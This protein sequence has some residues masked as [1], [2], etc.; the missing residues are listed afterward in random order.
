MTD[1]DG[2]GPDGIAGLPVDEAVDAVLARGVDEDRETVRA[3]LSEVAADGVVTWE[4]AEAALAH[5]SK[6]VSTPET[7][8]ELAAMEL[9]E[10]REAAEPVAEVDAV[11]S[12]LDAFAARLETVEERNV[13]LGTDLQA[14]VDRD[15]DLYAVARGVARLTTAA[16]RVQGTADELSTD[17]QEFQRWLANPAVRYDGLAED[18]AQGEQSIE[19]LTAVVD[20]IEDAVLT[21]GAADPDGEA[22]RSWLDGTLQHRVLELLAADLRAELA[23]IRELSGEAP[24]RAA[25]LRERLA[26]HEQRLTTLGDR[27]ESLALPA[28]TDRYGERVASFEATLDGVEPPV[29]WGAVQA[30]QRAARPGAP[31]AE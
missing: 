6:V 1:E 7:R 17:I 30:E 21:E 20:G 13:D 15:D 2:V 29:D 16:N 4:G 14:L 22:A 19:E 27:L 12:R 25:E 11:R 28:W 23:D 31:D 8:T 18:V 9:S 3:A 10:A 5:A 24:E 26:E